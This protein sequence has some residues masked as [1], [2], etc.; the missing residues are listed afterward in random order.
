MDLPSLHGFLNLNLSRFDFIRIFGEATDS[1]GSG[2]SLIGVSI[3]TL[4]LGDV[5]LKN[6]ITSAGTKYYSALRIVLRVVRK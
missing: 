4:E 3:F 5:L 2:G 1:S 6:G